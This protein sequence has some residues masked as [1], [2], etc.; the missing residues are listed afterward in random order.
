MDRSIGEYIMSIINEIT[1]SLARERAEYMDTELIKAISRDEY[2]TL[3]K[4]TKWFN[5]IKN[6]KKKRIL[7]SIEVEV[8]DSGI[9]QKV[10]EGEAT[11]FQNFSYKVKRK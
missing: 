10:V 9:S 7:K 8:Y 4:T 2:E 1:G 11:L 6:Y 3:R 5:I